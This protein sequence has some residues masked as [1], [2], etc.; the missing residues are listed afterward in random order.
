MFLSHPDPKGIQQKNADPGQSK[1]N[2]TSLSLPR[3]LSWLPRCQALISQQLSREQMANSNSYKVRKFGKKIVCKAGQH[4]G[5]SLPIPGPEGKW[6]GRDQ[7]I[8][9]QSIGDRAGDMPVRGNHLRRQLGVGMPGN[10]SLIS[11]F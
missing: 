7:N 4:A 1:S 6:E 11:V 8:R 2:L 3:C 5:C 10:E 9:R